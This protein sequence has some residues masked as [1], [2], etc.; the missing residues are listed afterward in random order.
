MNFGYSIRIRLAENHA[1]G[2]ARSCQLV[3]RSWEFYY[4]DGTVNRVQ[5]EA[6][7][8]KQPVLFR[9]LDGTSGACY[10]F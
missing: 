1:Q 2:E 9:R 5:G 4:E 7:V 8:G 3:D 10:F 6:V